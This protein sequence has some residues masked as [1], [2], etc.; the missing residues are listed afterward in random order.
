MYKALPRRLPIDRILAEVDALAV[1]DRE[2]PPAAIQIV[3]KAG[4]GKSTILDQ[5]SETLSAKNHARWTLI[6]TE[7]RERWSL[8]AILRILAET[9][10]HEPTSSQV[11]DAIG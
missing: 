3:G 9:L 1:R 6:D 5:V 11:A 2:S 10:R 7:P 4:S 8:L